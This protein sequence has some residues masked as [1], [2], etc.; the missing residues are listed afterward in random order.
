[1]RLLLMAIWLSPGQPPY[2]EQR[3][4][5]EPNARGKLNER[6][7]QASLATSGGTCLRI[8]GRVK[9]I[10]SVGGFRLVFLEQGRPTYLRDEAPVTTTTC[11]SKDFVMPA[12]F[13]ECKELFASTKE[14]KLHASRS[15]LSSVG[16]NLDPLHLSKGSTS[17][18]LT[19]NWCHRPLDMTS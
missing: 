2:Y 19:P 13:L 6:S 12:A 4:K 7:S 14:G 18:K 9:I 1:M 3:Q 11:S 17:T 8:E 15:S 10:L 5:I 16:C